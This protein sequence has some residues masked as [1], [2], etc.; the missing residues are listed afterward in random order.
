M[1][2]LEPHWEFEMSRA[3]AFIILLGVDLLTSSCAGGRFASLPAPPDVER[4][5][6]AI[7]G[8][9]LHTWSKGGKY[10]VTVYKAAQLPT[11]QDTQQY[12]QCAQELG[13]RNVQW[14]GS[15]S[16]RNLRSAIGKLSYIRVVRSNDLRA[17]QRSQPAP[18]AATF[19]ATVAAGYAH[20]L[21]TLSA[22]TF[23]R[24]HTLAM[25]QFSSVCG[26][27]CGYGHVVVFKK[28]SAG[29]VFEP[30]SASCSAWMS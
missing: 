22:I 4:D 7:Y 24:S 30:Q 15:F 3:V 29:W 27:L 9:F 23:N 26:G 17:L 28:T 8:T 10:T 11:W 2:H 18:E 25:F 19:A 6:V 20:S 12:V 13:E 16:F 1:R 21:V 14:G 5:A